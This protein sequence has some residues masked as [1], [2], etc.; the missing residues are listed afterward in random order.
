M[1]V[2]PVERT[3]LELIAVLRITLQMHLD[4]VAGCS[5]WDVAAGGTTRPG[6]SLSVAL[7]E[8][9]ALIEWAARVDSREHEEHP[10]LDEDNGELGDLDDLEEL[11][12]GAEELD[13]SW[14]IN[15]GYMSAMVGGTGAHPPYLPVV[16][17]AVDSRNGLV[18]SLVQG[19]V[20]DSIG[21]LLARMLATV[22]QNS[23]IRAKELLIPSSLRLDS[24]VSLFERVGGEVTRVVATPMVN[25][26]FREL[27]Q[28]FSLGKGWFD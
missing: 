2:L 27:H 4:I 23:G 8:D 12:L 7:R 14:E 17:L 24:L 18:V 3:L 19:E 10:I 9:R 15:W 28:K 25:E 16:M 26:V 13:A 1:P 20:G 22:A 11:L 6:G 21:G 5:P